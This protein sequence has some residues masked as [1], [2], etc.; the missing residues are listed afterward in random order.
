MADPEWKSL[1]PIWHD[2][3]VLLANVIGGHLLDRLLSKRLLTHDQYDSLNG[4]RKKDGTPNEE[5]ARELLQILKKSPHPSFDNFW[6]FLDTEIEGGRDIRRQLFGRRDTPP[7]LSNVDHR[8]TEPGGESSRRQ[9]TLLTTSSLP[10]QSAATDTAAVAA[11]VAL[12]P[13]QRAVYSDQNAES[14]QAAS[15]L[16]VFIEVVLSLKDAYKQH[17][18]AIRAVLRTYLA[19]AY[20]KNPDDDFLDL[21]EVFCEKLSWVKQREERVKRAK[22][23]AFVTN[24]Q[25]KIRILFPDS[26]SAK[27]EPNHQR[28]ETYL[29][30]VMQLK[31]YEL[32]IDVAEGSITLIISIPGRGLINMLVYLDQNLE[33][34]NFLLDLDRSARISFGKFPYV[35]ASVF[36]R[37]SFQETASNLRKSLVD[38]TESTELFCDE[39][40]SLIIHVDKRLKKKYKHHH[41]GVVSMAQ[42][43]S[44]TVLAKSANYLDE[45]RLLSYKCRGLYHSLDSVDELLSKL[46]V[47]QIALQEKTV[48]MQPK[49]NDPFSVV[50][51]LSKST[52][53]RLD[54]LSKTNLEAKAKIEILHRQLIFTPESVGR[55][56]RRSALHYACLCGYLSIAKELVDTGSAVDA[57][58]VTGETPLMAACQNSSEAFPMTAIQNDKLEV[59][60]FLVSKGCSIQLQ[61]HLGL[62]ALH[63]ACISGYV[64]SADFLITAAAASVNQTDKDGRGPLWKACS[65]NHLEIVKLLIDAGADVNKTDKHHGRG[66]LSE[67]S[68]NGH[69]EIS[70]LLIDAG[71]NVNETNWSGRGP[72]WKAS[73]DG[74]VEIAKLLIDAGADVNKT[75]LSGRGPLLEASSNGHVEIAKLLIDAGADVNKTDRNGRWPFLE[76]SSNGHVEIA[77]L[78]IDAE[79]KVNETDLVGKGPLLEASSHGHVEIA[80]LLIDAGANVNKTDKSGRGP[81]LA[82]SF[83]GHVE[84]AK[85]LIDAG[86]DVN[87]KDRNERGPLLEASSNGHVEIAKLLIDAGANVNA[88]DWIRKG[89]LWKAS[90]N[91]HVEI[92]KLLIDAGANVNETD[93]IGRGSLLEASSNGHVEIAKLLIDAGANVNETDEIGRGPLMMASSTGHVEISKLLI[94][95]GAAALQPE[96][97]QA[98]SKLIVFIEV[99]ESL[100][101]TYQLHAHAIR[102]FLRKYLAKAYSKNLDDDFLDLE[103]I[104]CENLSRVKQR[105]ERVKKAKTL[106]FVTDV[107]PKIRILFPNSDSA[108]YDPNHRVIETHL[109]RVMQLK[110]SDLE[111]DVAEG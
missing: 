62:D 32:E 8:R 63:Y 79:A 98:A 9:Q 83:N 100:K 90:S 56:A 103:E 93:W 105:E 77:K 34:L 15:K 64:L 49:V 16:L 87:K 21:A 44:T 35:L 78:L 14:G 91:G 73:S 68:S 102:A 45:S 41:Q 37:K 108:K 38:A 54:T 57:Q 47:T 2:T 53:I 75:Y 107:Q 70:K 4:L 94:D 17:A 25:P 27:Y 10:S 30:R 1:T 109:R 99:V 92:A 80:K 6:A 55:K 18:D 86:A 23:L 19:N 88:T 51:S 39:D 59:V 61:N 67:A 52:R 74:H 58:S 5:V 29:R 48:D 97:G 101:D 96:S 81:L 7:S 24:V 106:A 46:H 26:D 31:R 11:A 82:A 72:L 43:F 110:R 22:T 33:P 65:N 95:A 71:A 40:N 104:F 66:P 60:K 111:I 50:T 20:S 13:D 84:I 76:A 12:Q 85:L 42:V 69:V 36:G 3:V 89:P 28:I